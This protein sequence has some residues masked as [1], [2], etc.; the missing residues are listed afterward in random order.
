MDLQHLP[1]KMITPSALPYALAA[2]HVYS[3]KSPFFSRLMV[4][5]IRNAYSFNFS[6]DITYFELFSNFP[7]IER[8]T[9]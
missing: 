6:S 5:F 7:P 1:F 3:P 2:P 4:R 8:N 9:F